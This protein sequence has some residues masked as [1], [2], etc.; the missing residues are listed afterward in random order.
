MK[1][2]VFYKSTKLRR[3]SNFSKTYPKEV[4]ERF[5]AEGVETSPINQE[6]SCWLGDPLL[7]E[8]LCPSPKSV[9]L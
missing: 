4:G 6:V 3:L 2:L 7:K 1:E 5:V 8:T 9:P